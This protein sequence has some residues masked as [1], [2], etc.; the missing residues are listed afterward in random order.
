MALRLG[1][2]RINRLWILVIS[3]LVL[4]LFAT[5]LSITYLKNREKDIE[6]QLTTKVKGGPK[7]SVVV[8]TDDLPAGTVIREGL[9]AARDIAV[10]LVYKDT[11]TTDDFDAISGKPLLRPVQK[12]SPTDA[13]RYHRR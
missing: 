4:G 2:L 10:D 11:I 6:T 8:P 5:W 7:A 3:A 12:R 13:G 1:K 9:V